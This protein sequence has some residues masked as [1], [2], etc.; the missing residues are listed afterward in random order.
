MLSEQHGHESIT[1]IAQSQRLS[2]FEHVQR[3]AAE[4]GAARRAEERKI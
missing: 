1:G 3:M 4:D 2:R